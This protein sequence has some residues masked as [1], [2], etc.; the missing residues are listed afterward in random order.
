MTDAKGSTRR[1]ILRLSASLGVAGSISSLAPPS[2][3]FARP[4]S[5]KPNILFILADDLGYADVSCYGRQEYQTTAIDRLAAEGMRFT[6]AYANSA[7]CSATRTAL[8]TGRYQYRLPIGLEEPLA[9]RDLGLPPSHPTLP[10]I[11]KAAGYDTS[12]IG[13][14]HLGGLPKY[15]PLKSGYNHFWGFRGGGVD[16]FRHS[17]V[18]HHD[19]WDDQKEIYRDGYLTDLLGQRAIDTIEASA[20]S[21]RPFFISLHFN[22]PH[23]PW[24]GPD[25]QA[26][27]ARMAASGNKLQDFFRFDDGSLKTY[28]EMVTSMDRAIGKILSTIDRLDL[29]NDTIVVFTSDNGGERFSNTWP[30]TGKKGELL[31]GGLRIPAIVRWPALVKAGSVSEQV[32]ISM[33]WLPTLL[34]AAGAHPDSRYPSEG[35]DLSPVLEGGATAERTLFWRYLNLSQQACRSGDWK[36]LKILDNHFLFNVVDDPLERANWKNRQPDIFA[37][38]VERYRKWEMTMLPL[39]PASFTKGF[40]GADLADHYGATS[41]RMI[42]D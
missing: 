42:A 39:D 14:W 15:G 12:L 4:A 23:W 20:R 18:G 7:V 24:E 38:L 19:L 36:Y 30:F 2:R 10:S 13:K 29:A 21:E 35:M 40:T 33:D 8:I 34:A 27:S 37:N 6:Q 5:R 11:L 16:Y 41:D 25:D 32:T 22:A 1:D 31:E 26:E 9:G 28:G 17:A 3:L